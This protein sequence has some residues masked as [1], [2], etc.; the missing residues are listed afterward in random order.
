MAPQ[1]SPPPS[2]VAVLLSLGGAPE[3]VVRVSEPPPDEWLVL[4]RPTPSWPGDQADR[5]RP[6][7][8]RLYRLERSWRSPDHQWWRV[9]NEGR[10]QSPEPAYV[11]RE[12][13]A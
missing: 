11:Y 12:V 2:A 5:T 10:T 4:A 7:S 9:Y 1:T 13:R 3:R 8:R 6:L